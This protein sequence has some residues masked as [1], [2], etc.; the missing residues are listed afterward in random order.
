M[1]AYQINKLCHRLYHDQPFRDSVKIDPVKAITDWPLSTVERK[2]LLEGDIKWLYEA[3]V[4]PFLLGHV[5]RWNLFGVTPA[6]YVERIK[7]AKDPD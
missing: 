4:H 3:G 7:D 2:A 5:T 6:L 1:S